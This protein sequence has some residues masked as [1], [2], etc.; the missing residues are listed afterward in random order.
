[1][2]VD[3]HVFFTMDVLWDSAD[4]KLMALFRGFRLGD[5]TRWSGYNRTIFIRSCRIVNF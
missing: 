1:M 5:K 3:R 4:S 2:S